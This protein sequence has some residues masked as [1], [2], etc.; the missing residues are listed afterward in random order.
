M[1]VRNLEL[2]LLKIVNKKGVGKKSQNP[3]DFNVAT[4]VDEDVNVFTLNLSD[5]VVAALGADASELRNL[6]VEATIE[7]RPKGFDI[8]GTITAIKPV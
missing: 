3:Y 1:I 8:G 7:F 2:T 5:E 4:V 6:P